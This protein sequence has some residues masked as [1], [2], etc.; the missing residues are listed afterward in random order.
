MIHIF[1]GTKAQYVKT[2][3]VIHELNKRGIEYNLIDSGQH[4]KLQE[5][6]REFFGIRQP[7]VMLRK[8]RKDITNPLVLIEW[9]FTEFL[10]NGIFPGGA[11]KRLFRGQ[12]GIC[13]VHG[14]T[15]TTLL[16]ALIAKRCGI[17][18]AHLEAGLRSYSLFD[19]FPE[20][21]IRLIVM[22]TSDILFASSGWARNNLEKMGVKGKVISISANTGLDAI[23]YSMNKYK[24]K[25]P[26]LKDY[27][28]VSIH[29][30]ERLISMKRLTEIID[31]IERISADK[32]VIFPIHPPTNVFL[33]R[34]GILNK[35]QNMKA[36]FCSGLYD[37]GHFLSLLKHADFVVTDG[38]SIQEEA[39]YLGVPC[40]VA[41]FHTERQE[42][43]GENA[44]LAGTHG[45]AVY[46]FLKN[47]KDLRRPDITMGSLNPS[48]EIVD[49]IQNQTNK[50]S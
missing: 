43:L 31:L 19:P 20:E 33:K 44:I 8:G 6:F 13:L 47:Y 32:K 21:L 1:I 40:L 34:Y 39:Y 35:L 48:A 9:L 42:G 28:L 14:D 25:E 37:H 24:I 27:C 7:D 26:D 17:K 50:T 45:K 18:V 3:P 10:K 29:R 36:V 30:F 22:R 23:R 41:R 38:G 4:A 11:K 12:G 16:S 15:P 5:E 46:D 2:A 49:F